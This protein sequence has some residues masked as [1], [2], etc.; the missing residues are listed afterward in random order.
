MFMTLYAATVDFTT[1]T[2]TTLPGSETTFPEWI[3]KIVNG[4]MVMSALLLLVYLLW[5]GI[6]WISAGGDS[7]KIQAAR[8]R[9]TQ[10]VIGIIVLAASIAIFMLLQGFLGISIL[11]FTGG[12]SSGST[13][14]TAAGSTVTT[15][16]RTGGGSGFTLTRE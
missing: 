6:S 1:A 13:P 3:A 10:A 4:V 14:G 9:I 12:T 5:G 15:T 16:R 8:D 7:S 2:N 11:N